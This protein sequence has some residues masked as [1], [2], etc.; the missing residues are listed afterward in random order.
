MPIGAWALRRACEQAR[1]WVEDSGYDLFVSVNVSARQLQDEALADHVAEALRD[2]RLASQRLALEVTE[3]QLMRNVEQ[4]AAVLC[5][6]R[7]LGAQ[8]AI[9]DFGSGYSS[10][11]Q[12]ERLPVDILK[13]DREFAGAAQIGGEHARLLT[14]VIEIGDSLDLSTIAEGIETPEQLRQ[15]RALGYSLGQGYLFSK[16]VPA[17]KVEALLAAS[18]RPPAPL[19]R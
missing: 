12:L 5:A 14:A 6:V 7:E 19:R 3:T 4:A 13:V 9:D 11:S 18:P 2:S 15:L 17:R 10:L 1:A 16:P 8:V